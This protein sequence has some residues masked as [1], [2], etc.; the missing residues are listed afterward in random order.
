MTET[1]S[2]SESLQKEKKNLG[3]NWQLSKS[4]CAKN[5]FPKSFKGVCFIT[6]K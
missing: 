4:A 3:K 5:G 1:V 6:M 2:I